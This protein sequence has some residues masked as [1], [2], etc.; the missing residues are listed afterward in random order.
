M[1]WIDVILALISS[2]LG[3]VTARDRTIQKEL[4]Y[5]LD[6]YKLMYED[7]RIRYEKTEKLLEEQRQYDRKNFEKIAIASPA[8]A[9]ELVFE[10]SE[11]D[12]LRD[13][14]DTVSDLSTP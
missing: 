10:K 9:L 12:R 3:F 2:I 8:R 7:M 11:R 1:T 4:K 14:E 13:E 6:N 5:K